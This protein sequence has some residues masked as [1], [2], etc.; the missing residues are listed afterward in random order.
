MDIKQMLS[1]QKVA[2]YKNFSKA[3][4]E[5][6][7]SQPTVTSHILDLEKELD[8]KLLERG[9]SVELTLFGEHFLD[10][11]NQ[12]IALQDEAVGSIDDLKKGKSGTLKLALTGSAGYWLFP[13]L[14]KFKR[15]HNTVDINITVTLCNQTIDSVITRK[16]HF[17]FIKTPNPGFVHPLLLSKEVELDENIL[18]FSPHHKFSKLEE[19]TLT[20]ICKEP[21][22]AYARNTNYWEQILEIFHT[23]GLN[24]KV[25]METYDYQS[26]K[27][28][29]Q[30][31][32]GIAFLPNIC[33]KE[34]IKQGILKTIPIID[35]PPITRYSIMLY[36]KDMVLNDLLKSFLKMIIIHASTLE[37]PPTAV[38]QL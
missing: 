36:R 34:E 16:V 10:Y 8:V 30:T 21:M 31:S 38:C 15:Y 24:P 5:L 37:L 4:K 35:C 28:L 19:I 29:L 7:L 22:I 2:H 13:L 18:V 6:F 27:L 23:A 9:K 17:G 33:V 12:I 1:F 20:D 11:V 26:I 25:S 3:S 32:L 14:D